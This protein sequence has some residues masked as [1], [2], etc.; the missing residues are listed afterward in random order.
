V[1]C[2]TFRTRRHIDCRVYLLVTGYALPTGMGQ[3]TSGSQRTMNP[4]RRC[5]EASNSIGGYSTPRERSRMSQFQIVR[6]RDPPWNAMPLY[7]SASLQPLSSGPLQLGFV[8]LAYFSMFHLHCSLISLSQQLPSVLAP[9]QAIFCL[10]LTNPFQSVAFCL[11]QLIPGYSFVV[12]LRRDCGSS[13]IG[14][15]LIV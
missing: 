1:R 7:R 12:S 9:V 3:S 6:I 15:W 11:S 2:F 4:G 8:I 5:T 10:G 14:R 13:C